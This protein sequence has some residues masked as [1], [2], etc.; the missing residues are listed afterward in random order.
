MAEVHAKSA[1][2]VTWE[3]TGGVPEDPIV[4]ILNHRLSASSVKNLVELLY[5][6]LSY[7]FRDKLLVAK[8]RRANQYQ[9]TMTPFQHIHCGDNPWLHARLVSDVR[10]VDGTPTWEEPP[11]ETER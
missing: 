7:S 2:L 6:S 9:A 8:D 3:G 1:W 4:A 5:A 11:S 10:V